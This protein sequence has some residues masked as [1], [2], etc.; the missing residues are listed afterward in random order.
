MGTITQRKTM[1]GK[2]RY[3]AQVRV[4]RQGL[5]DFTRSK[6]FSKESLAKDWIKR[7]EAAIELDESI[8]TRS[9]TAVTLRELIL[10]Y[11]DEAA[12]QKLT[13]SPSPSQSASSPVLTRPPYHPST[14]LGA[15]LACALHIL[16]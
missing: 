8:I 9:S 1:D 14:G 4:K 2:V 6:T 11:R 7:L 3:R 12:D 10:R 16:D 13:H 5:P 15:Q